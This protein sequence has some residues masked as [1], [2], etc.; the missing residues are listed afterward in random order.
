MGG[1]ASPKVENVNLSV[2]HSLKS[3][4]NT[5]DALFRMSKRLISVKYFVFLQTNFGM[6]FSETQA[7]DEVTLGR[8]ILGCF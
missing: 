4:L 5:G 1:Q 8:I 3:S 6:S 7:L 2:M